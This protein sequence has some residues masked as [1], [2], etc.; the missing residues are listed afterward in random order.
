M[1]AK[2]VAN[3]PAPHSDQLHRTAR[4]SADT[5]VSTRKHRLSLIISIFVPLLIVITGSDG[6]M[7]TATKMKLPTS[8]NDNKPAQALLVRQRLQQ[9]PQADLR[10]PGRQVNVLV[11]KKSL[12]ETE[13]SLL[14]Y[15]FQQ[16]EH[17]TCLHVHRLSPDSVNPFAPHNM[18]LNDT[19]RNFIYIF[20]SPG[21]TGEIFSGRHPTMGLSS[22]GCVRQGRQSMVLTDLAFKWPELVL[23]YHIMRSLGVDKLERPDGPVRKLLNMLPLNQKI[24]GGERFEATDQTKP[25]P[26]ASI[27]PQRAH[28]SWSPGDFEQ[29]AYIAYATK[30]ADSSNLAPGVQQKTMSVRSQTKPVDSILSENDLTQIKELYDCKDYQN[31]LSPMPLDDA[32]SVEPQTSQ[33]SDESSQ[34]TDQQPAALSNELVPKK[35]KLNDEDHGKLPAKLLDDVNQELSKTADEEPTHEL[36]DAASAIEATKRIIESLL[37]PNEQANKSSDVANDSSV[38][39][40]EQNNS[41][42]SECKSFESCPVNMYQGGN[43]S[44]TSDG[45]LDA[46]GESLHRH[47]PEERPMILKLDDFHA[48]DPQLKQAN[49]MKLSQ[50]SNDTL[51]T[52]RLMN[53][54]TNLGDFLL[55]PPSSHEHGD[56]QQHWQPDYAQ[57]GNN[58]Q[59]PKS[60]MLISFE[61]SNNQ[62]KDPVSALASSQVLKL[63]SC[64]CQTMMPKSPPPQ[65]TPPPTPSPVTPSPTREPTV[66]PT[67]TAMPTEGPPPSRTPPTLFPTFGPT[68]PTDA[69][70]NCT[71][72]DY[73][74]DD[75]S[76]CNSP[77]TPPTPTELPPATIAPSPLP[78]TPQPTEEHT[79]TTEPPTTTTTEPPTTTTHEPPITTTTE[80]PTT[81]T[82]PPTKGTSATESPPKPTPSSQPNTTSSSNGGLFTASACDQVEWVKPNK[83]VYASARIVWDVD[84]A[85]QNY[86]LC[87]NQLNDEL[88]PGKTH[89]FY[90]KISQ[91]GKAY[92]THNFSVL[93][94]PEHVN[95]AWVQKNSNSFGRTNFP[96]VGG[97]SKQ[98]DPY[99]VSRCLVKD[100]NNDIITLIGYINNQGV[101]WF[102]FDDIQIECSQYDV[103]ACV[104]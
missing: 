2:D 80:P 77:T 53:N 102:P 88:I 44:S 92:E 50:L 52:Y 1:A 86:F 89:G 45:P 91:E 32:P 49:Q 104:N 41:T 36:Q 100:E 18:H 38:K 78:P 42:D 35:S 31:R 81:T 54:P 17:K 3:K 62:L 57:H 16:L 9:Q 65:P 74:D 69:G 103:L 10:W 56:H 46:N 61:Q 64:T 39:I 66:T 95:L 34:R 28:E 48:Q 19:E 59:K 51:E 73:D 29:P 83:T 15:V 68:F 5:P 67:P 76:G 11:D 27:E 98:K 72:D 8:A 58:W 37:N 75:G 84:R 63:C 14:A 20:K 7:I 24:G 60:E 101:G 33:S 43:D 40:M 70:P 71:G 87:N 82:P 85:N 90:C 23:R 4:S 97:Y 26:N 79:T 6:A 21:R 94:K 55:Q 47:Q 22:L 30:P 25:A 96:V 99:I 93:T 13:Q 12:N